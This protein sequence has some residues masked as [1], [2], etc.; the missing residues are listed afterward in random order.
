M[1]VIA[2]G[3]G[4]QST[5]LIVLAAQGRIEPV[6][7]VL[8][9][10]VGE[11]AE[12]PD[13]LRYVREVATPW[14][15]EHGITVT[16]IGYTRKD[17]TPVDLY[18]RVIREADNGGA[19]S[20][21]LRGSRTG[22]P[23]N[24]TCTADHKVRALAKW[25]KAHGA[26]KQDP[27]YML[28]G[29]STDEFHRA[30]NGRDAP[31]ERRVFP[32]LDLRLD[33]AACQQIIADAGLPVPA[34]SACWFCPFHTLPRWAE[35]ARDEP[36]MFE[37]AAEL[38]EYVNMRRAEHGRDPMYLTGRGVPLRDTITAAQNMLPIFAL[39]D[40]GCDEGVCFV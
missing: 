3:G 40:D 20:I 15:A 30:T 37:R 14:A 25:V 34:K 38:E 9:S 1:R 16:E 32:L 19:T 33:R 28:M 2:Y 6:D 4:V 18:E 8:F 11:K 17:G 12:H 22:A 23:G 13:S 31:H 26:T 35:V 24:R 27:A 21:P 36:E 29:I 10:N 5:A 39:G 7:A